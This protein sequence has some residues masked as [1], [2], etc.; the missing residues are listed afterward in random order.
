VSIDNPGQILTLLSIAAIIIGVLFWLI[1][2]RL[3]KVMA[4][5]EPN[6]GSSV[7]DQLDRIEKKVDAVE[8]KVDGH[9]N[10]H[11]NQKGQ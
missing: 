5:F 10:W 3:N 4:E 9:I 11:M 8:T 7:R 6:G 2:S 1:D